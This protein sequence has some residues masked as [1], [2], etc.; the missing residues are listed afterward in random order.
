MQRDGVETTVMMVLVVEMMIPM[1]VTM[2]T[3]SPLRE[4]IYRR[5]QPTGELFS[6]W[7]STP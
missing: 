1:A 5:F 4:G 3:I 7:F 6:L 2:A